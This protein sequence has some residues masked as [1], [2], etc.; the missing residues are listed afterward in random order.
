MKLFSLDNSEKL[1]FKLGQARS[2]CVLFTEQKQRST[3]SSH[4]HYLTFKM[5]YLG[6]TTRSDLLVVL[7]EMVID[8]NTFSNYLS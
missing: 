8:G 3:A 4:Y 6:K 7:D 1:V 5:I 2:V